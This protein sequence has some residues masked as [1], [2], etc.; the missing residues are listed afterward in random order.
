M[1]EGET[2]L[3]LRKHISIGAERTNY[4]LLMGPQKTR[5]K[6]KRK[7]KQSPIR[8]GKVKFPDFPKGKKLF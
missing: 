8:K 4:M 2:F 6:R 7:R 3:I 5:T 1:K